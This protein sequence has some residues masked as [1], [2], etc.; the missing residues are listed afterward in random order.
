ML[1]EIMHTLGFAA[2]GAPHHTQSGHVSENPTDLMYAGDA[3]WQ[4]SAL[5]VGHDDYYLTGRT[6]ILDLS[7]SVFLDPLPL[8]PTPPPGWP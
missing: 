6:D 1:H 7:R 2:R 5:D 3:A 4:P 8:D